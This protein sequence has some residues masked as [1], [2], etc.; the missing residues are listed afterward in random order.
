MLA[1][2]PAVGRD[3]AQ[4]RRPERGGSG[5]IR[6]MA[7][8]ER[9]EAAVHHRDALPEPLKV[10]MPDY[11]WWIDTIARWQSALWSPASPVRMAPIWPSSSCPRDMRCTESYA[12]L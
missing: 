11:H 5:E 10:R 6:D 4:Q 9:I 3:A 1:L 7:V 8:V 12:A 2:D